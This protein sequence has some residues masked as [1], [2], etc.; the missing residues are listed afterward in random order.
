MEE[1]KKV[2]KGLLQENNRT[3]IILFVLTIITT[4]LAGAEWIYGRSFIYGTHKMGWQEFLGGFEY[5]IPF[6]LILTTHEF[7]HY[8][9]ARYHN[10]KT[11]LPFYIPMW[12]GFAPSIGTMGAFIRIKERANSRIQNFDIGVAG[13]LSGFVVAFIVLLI[14]FLNLPPASYVLEI[15][16]EYEALGPNYDQYVYTQDTFILKND[17]AKYNPEYA[18]NLPDTLFY[19]PDSPAFQL[20]TTILFDAMYGLVPDD[21]LDRIPHPAEIMHYPWL[22]AGFLALIFT[23]LNMLP[24]GQ[25]DGGHVIY[26]LFGAQKHAIIS[27]VFFILLIVYSGVGIISPYEAPGSG[28]S[29]EYAI[30]IPLYVFFLYYILARVTPKKTS[31]LLI[32][33]SIFAFQFLIVQMFPAA[34]GYYGWLFFSFFI[35][36]FVGVDYPPA[37]ID[38]ELDTRRQL[39]GWFALIVFIISF[40]LQPLILVGI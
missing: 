24:I 40:S 28:D 32:A 7:G 23:A 36:R 17:I 29:I 31:R 12:F 4:T 16:P 30:Y 21:K 27:R 10:I 38:D 33:I 14:G 15:H 39:L 6:L 26:G 20:G 22:L 1:K 2:R 35:G 8:L 11:S 37:R 19:S 5:S 13:P 18:E 9:T 34:Q 3:H 25:L